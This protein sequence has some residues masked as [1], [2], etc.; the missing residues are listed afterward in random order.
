MA[1]NQE[2]SRLE[3]G[4][5]KGLS[6]EIRHGRT[7]HNMSSSSLRKK[8]D[9]TLVSKVPCGLLRKF[10]A[11]LQEVILGTKLSVLFPAIPLAIAAQCYGFGRPWVFAL[12][13]LGLTPLAERVSFLT[14]QLAYYTGP[15]V[16]GLL[17]ATCGNVTELII[18]IF[19]LKEKKI[20]VVKY[21]LLGSV[22]SNL[23]LVLGTS[24]F[25]GGIANLGKE[26]KFDRRQ[27]DVNSLMLL[28]ALLC[29][30]LPVLFGFAGTSTAVDAANSTLHLSRASSIVMLIAYSAYLVF[31]LWTH[32]QLF[33]AQEVFIY[34]IFLIMQKKIKYIYIYIYIISLLL[35]HDSAKLKYLG[36]ADSDDDD[37]NS[38]ETPVIGFWSGFVWLAGM[39][40][41][42]AVLSE[43][44]VGTIE[45]ASDSW[46]L[47]VS[48]LSIILLPIV[49]NAA[50][51]AGA[52]IFAFKN[53]LDISLGV[54]LGSATQIAMFVVPLCVIVAWIMGINMD[55]NF[56]LLE[57]GSLTL[58]IVA[59][60]FTLQ[61]G[62]SHYMKGFILLLCYVVIGACFFVNKSP[63]NNRATISNAVPGMT[64]E[65][66]FRV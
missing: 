22:L 61:D 26:Q 4:N 19:A 57:T 3:N 35:I 10:L 48:F 50:E 43:Y 44:V 23:L 34:L 32:R 60:A 31:Q 25:C 29:H 63:L 53:K 24:L 45:D 5:L 55:L 37:V 6:R 36:E 54:A 52:I 21:S 8:S 30:L 9:L 1:S 64:T 12:S 58:A 13:L 11:N 14:E 66:I 62:T 40:I 2:A 15:T 49:G 46:G 41:I 33:E 56:N 17:N 39:T 65:P 20:A 18:A 28:L 59:T 27:G 16:G 38:E 51:H 42:I 47:S 7:A